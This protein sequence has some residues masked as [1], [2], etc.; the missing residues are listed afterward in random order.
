[1]RILHLDGGKE[2]RGGQWQVLR[3]IEGLYKAGVESTLLA[4]D[5]APL[6]RVAYE[7]GWRTEPLGIARAYSLAGQ[8]D[9]LH[10]HDGH[11]HTVGAIV[12]PGKLLVSRRVAFPPKSRLKYRRARHFLAVS[13]L[14]KGIL[15]AGGVPQEKISVVYDGVPL[16]EPSSGKIGR[17]HV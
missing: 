3:L 16:L 15:M 2:L 6:F 4:R 1:M 11:G 9:L 13:E 7:R 17:A 5:G 8:H 12:G 10:A 14:V